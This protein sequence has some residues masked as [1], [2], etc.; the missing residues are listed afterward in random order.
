MKSILPYFSGTL[1]RKSGFRKY[2]NCT[3]NF[4]WLTSKFVAFE[5]AGI[6]DTGDQTLIMRTTFCFTNSQHGT[7]LS[8]RFSIN[9][10]LD[11]AFHRF[12]QFPGL[13][14][15]IYSTGNILP[16]MS[17]KRNKGFH[18]ISINVHPHK[19]F[20]FINGAERIRRLGKG[21]HHAVKGGG[22][23]PGFLFLCPLRLGFGRL[24]QQLRSVYKELHADR[25]TG[26]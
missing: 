20:H 18:L 15:D 11:P 12:G 21:P 3:A 16:I 6:A 23:R 5:P 1:K 2:G 9:V 24:I 4:I 8:G 10:L 25:E 17:H 22:R 14:G 26:C 19:H 7:I 13:K